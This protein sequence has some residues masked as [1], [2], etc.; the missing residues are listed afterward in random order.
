M[1]HPSCKPRSQ[2][3]KDSHFAIIPLF[4]LL[5][6]HWDRASREDLSRRAQGTLQIP[7]QVWAAADADELVWRL[8]WDC[9]LEYNGKQMLSESWNAATEK[10]SEDLP[11]TVVHKIQGT[12]FVQ[13][14]FTEKQAFNLKQAQQSQRRWN[15]RNQS[16]TNWK[17][18]RC[19]TIPPLKVLHHRSEPR[20]RDQCTHNYQNHSTAWHNKFSQGTACKQ[21]LWSDGFWL[22][23]LSLLRKK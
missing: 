12:Q 23:L 17:R 21:I 5:H 13:W 9:W 16:V 6:Q 18:S 20:G 19:P 3:S 7:R 11:S 1:V 14:F 15:W 2:C 4:L 22:M 8:P 10:F